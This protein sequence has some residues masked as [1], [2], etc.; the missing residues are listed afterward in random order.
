MD[1]ILKN[2]IQSIQIGVE[3]YE[4]KDS[5]RVLSSV[6]NLSAGVLLIF[7]EKLRLLSPPGSNESLLKQKVR[8]EKESGSVSFVG[9]GKKTVDVQQI[10]VFFMPTVF[11]MEIY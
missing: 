4:S 6:R 7:K 1:T 5:R 9:V 11:Y 8:P 3:D 2:A 10:N